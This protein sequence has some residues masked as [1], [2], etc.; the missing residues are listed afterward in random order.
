MLFIPLFFSAY[1]EQNVLVGRTAH[2]PCH[3]AGHQFF[4]DKEPVQESEDD[5]SPKHQQPQLHS[6]QPLDMI[7]LI[8]WY[9]GDDISGS[10]FYSV[11]ARL[12]QSSMTNNPN[13][14]SS[15][16]NNQQQQQNPITNQWKHFLMDPYNERAKFVFNHHYV[17]NNISNQQTMTIK[18]S[19]ENSQQSSSSSGNI[20]INPF[21]LIIDPVEEQDQGLYWCRVD[22]RWTRTTISKV[23]LNVYGM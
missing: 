15:F 5:P 14:S 4:N 9:H 3:L 20:L 12:Q 18:S 17:N 21:M 22:Y 11:D 8:L 1:P 7:Q 2:L 10:P 16:H 19:F 6:S 13:D 23:M